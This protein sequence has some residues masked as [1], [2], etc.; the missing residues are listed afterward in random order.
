MPYVT[1]DDKF[2]RH[3]KVIAAMML[4]PLAPWLWICG[5]SY[6]REHM[7]GGLIAPL[8]V[9]TLM[10]LYKPKIRNALVTVNLWEDKGDGWIFVHDYPEFNDRED[11]QR[12]ARSAKAKHAAKQRWSNA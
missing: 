6:C 12:A 1:L 9:P 2:P 3:P 10:P 5:T 7:T 4:D 11:D 8:V